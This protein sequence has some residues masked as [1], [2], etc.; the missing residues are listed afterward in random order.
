MGLEATVRLRV[1]Q[2]LQ[3]GGQAVELL[4]HVLWQLLVLL[5]PANRTA[6][7]I[8][9]ALQEEKKREKRHRTL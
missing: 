7:A 5:I 4:F 8:L 3:D 9:S 2:Q 1:G 6:S